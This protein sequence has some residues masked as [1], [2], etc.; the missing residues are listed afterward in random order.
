MDDELEA[1]LNRIRKSRKAADEATR[2]ERAPSV[3]VEDIEVVLGDLDRPYRV[4]GPITARVT[5]G[6][7][8]NKARTVEDVN[9][10]LREVAVRMGAN[11]VIGATYERGIS[12][13]SW[14]AL[15]ANGT[16]VLAQPDEKKCPYC[17]ELIK[18]E[19]IKC[20]HCGSDLSE[21]PPSTG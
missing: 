4:I 11:A 19:A 5:A 15:T 1:A 20:K 3:R 10:K 2:K 6:A 9:S 12:A 14:K 13:T 17:A 8:W 21:S 18:S 16:A 7:A